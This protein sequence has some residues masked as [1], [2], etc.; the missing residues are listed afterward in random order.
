MEAANRGAAL[1]GGKSIGLN[2]RLPHEQFVN[3]Y[4]PPELVFNFH[5]FFMRKFWFVYLAKAVVLFPGGY[6]TL[7]E[8]FEIRTLVQTH[9]MR[10]RMPIVFSVP[11][12]GTGDQFRR[13]GEIWHDQP[14]RP[15]PLPSDGFNRRSLRNHHERSCRK[16]AREP[17]SDALEPVAA[18]PR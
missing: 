5:Y 17:R 9:K 18:E 7:D 13:A 11:N 8:L 6:G 15:R 10:K 2:I 4:V 1:A 3:P 16:R 12:T 14:R